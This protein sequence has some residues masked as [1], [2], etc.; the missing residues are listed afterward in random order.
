MFMYIIHSFNMYLFHHCSPGT[1]PWGVQGD[2]SSYQFEKYLHLQLILSFCLQWGKSFLFDSY[3]NLNLNYFKK[4]SLFEAKC[5]T[6]DEPSISYHFKDKPPMHCKADFLVW[7]RRKESRNR[8]IL[9]SASKRVYEFIPLEPCDGG[10]QYGL[11]MIT[12]V[13]TW[14][15]CFPALWLGEVCNFSGLCVPIYKV[16]TSSQPYLCLLVN[17]NQYQVSKGAQQ[18]DCHVLGTLIFLLLS[19]GCYLKETR[20]VWNK[21]IIYECT[22]MYI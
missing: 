3:F 13:H 5:L 9:G 22:H 20:H 21:Q 15:S 6:Q 19:R 14:L 10:R 2:P 11:G 8:W 17:T 7:P 4:N 18:R 16:G 12:R 1:R